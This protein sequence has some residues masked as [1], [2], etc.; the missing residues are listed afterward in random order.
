[1]SNYATSVKIPDEI[2]EKLRNQAEEE[3]RTVSNMIVYILKQYYKDK[4][5]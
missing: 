2:L 4:A 1:M 5:E 3:E